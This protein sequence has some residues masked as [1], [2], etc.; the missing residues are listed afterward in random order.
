M[1]TE[2]WNTVEIS[3]IVVR[4]VCTERE[5]IMIVESEACPN[6]E[7]FLDILHRKM[8]LFQRDEKGDRVI[9][10]KSAHLHD[11]ARYITAGKRLKNSILKGERTLRSPFVS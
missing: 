1:S 4:F 6:N 11:I 2:V 3:G 7:Y 10:I 5:E 8:V 9:R